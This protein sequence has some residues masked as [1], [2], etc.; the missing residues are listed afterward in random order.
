MPY[1]EADGPLPAVGDGIAALLRR[2]R[3]P[4]AAG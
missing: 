4:S 3:E 2:V 1:F